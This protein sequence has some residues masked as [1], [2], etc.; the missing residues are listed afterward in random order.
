[1]KKSFSPVR[2]YSGR[3]YSYMMREQK[4]LREIFFFS[5]SLEEEMGITD[6]FQARVRAWGKAIEM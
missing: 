6:T 3:E 5:A 4:G 1:M 2:L